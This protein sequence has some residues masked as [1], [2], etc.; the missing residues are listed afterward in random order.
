MILA[1]IETALVDSWDFFL[2]LV[3]VLIPMFIGT[4]FLVGLAQECPPPEKVEDY[5]SC[6]PLQWSSSVSRLA[7]D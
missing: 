2:H 4:S 3:T 6:T 5:S 1:G 7:L